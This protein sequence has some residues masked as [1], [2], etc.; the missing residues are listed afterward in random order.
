MKFKDLISLKGKTA[1]VTGGAGLLGR[2][3]CRGLAEL[4]AQVAIVDLKAPE[5]F[6][7]ELT[8]EF[9]PR[10]L[11]I[12]CDVASPE[13]VSK[14]SQAVLERFQSVDILLNNAAS[15]SDDLEKFFARFE[16]YSIEEWRNVMSVNLDGMFLVAQAIGKNMKSGAILQTSSIYGILGPDQSIYEESSYLGR[17]INTPA[18]YSASK[19]GIIGLT[20]YLATYWAQK[21][22][23][24]NCL[25]PGGVESGQNAAF[26]KKYSARVPLGRMAQAIEMVPP[27]MFLVSDAASYITGQCIAVD[28]GLSAW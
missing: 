7:D 22:I 6:A 10:F 12:A 13:A 24:V 14:M 23:R 25:V 20:R 18:V 19:S 16:D 9:G 21:G 2:A 11:G 26:K 1:V 27:A 8:K 28:G 5:S 4:G 15:K 3:F 17:P